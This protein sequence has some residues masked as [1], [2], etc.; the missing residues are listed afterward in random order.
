MKRELTAKQRVFVEEYLVDLNATQAAIRA[1]YSKK[2]AQRIGS[3]NLSKPLVAEAIQKAMEKR[4]ERT[5]I[6]ADAVLEEL[7]KLGFSN[8]KDYAAVM[9]DGSGMHLDLSELTRD[10]AAAI[11][12]IKSTTTKIGEGL[13]SESTELKLADKKPS[14]ELLGKHLELFTENVKID[15]GT[16]NFNITIPK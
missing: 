2:T 4:S 10:Q 6:T 5:E 11:K 16:V 13:V 9:S 7:A 15:H 1:G 12:S 3:E 8:M 14:L